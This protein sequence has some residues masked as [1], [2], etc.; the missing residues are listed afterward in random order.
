MNFT[1]FTI[2][3]NIKKMISTPIK[4]G[5]FNTQDFKLPPNDLFILQSIDN[6]HVVF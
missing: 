1:C 5:H 3:I 2:N 4:W 6:Q